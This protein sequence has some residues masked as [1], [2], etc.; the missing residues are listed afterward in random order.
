MSTDFNEGRT[1][2]RHRAELLATSGQLHGR[3][4]ARSHGRRQALAIASVCCALV[5]L[6]L[7]FMRTRED[8]DVRS[9]VRTYLA[10]ML[11][12]FVGVALASVF[13]PAAFMASFLGTYLMLSAQTRS[14]SVLGGEPQP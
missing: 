9:C 5:G 1:T 6:G 11:V 14:R 7:R 12:F 3:H 8:G 10:G 13:G 2:V 4:R